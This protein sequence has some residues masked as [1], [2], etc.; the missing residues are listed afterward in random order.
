MPTYQEIEAIKQA[1]AGAMQQVIA[2]VQ[3]KPS[4]L[5][6]TSDEAVG[7]YISPFGAVPDGVSAARPVAGSGTLQAPLQQ[8]QAAE[9]PSLAATVVALFVGLI[10]VYRLIHR[11]LA[12]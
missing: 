8:G 10:L 1:H 7:I 5:S 3:P 9:Q 11:M 12:D 6:L 4:V 2:R